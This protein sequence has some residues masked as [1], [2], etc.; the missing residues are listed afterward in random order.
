MDRASSLKSIH[1]GPLLHV[2]IGPS[3]WGLPS[4]FTVGA[5]T[6]RFVEA[7]TSDGALVGLTSLEDSKGNTIL[8]LDFHYY[9]RI[10][11]DGATLL[12]R[13][14][15]EK[16]ATR[17]VFDCFSLLG[18]QPIRDP[19]RTAD[20]IR[21]NKLGVSA[22]PGSQRWEISPQ[23]DAGV[24][25]LSIPYDWSRFEETLVLAHHRESDFFRKMASAIFAFNWVERRVDVFPQ[26]WFNTGSYDFGYQWI[27]RVARHRDGKI[28]GDGT[29]LGR[30]ELDETNRSIK[31]WLTSEIFYS[32]R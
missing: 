28:V 21:R 26:D 10:L 23:L 2:A 11:P 6:F 14:L 7:K 19:K 29:R 4:H 5:E 27:T 15:G 25:S 13:E 1:D 20:K 12:W 22:V 17:I 18:L 8:I 30:F 31:K 24:H 16:N 32:I 3:P 9:A